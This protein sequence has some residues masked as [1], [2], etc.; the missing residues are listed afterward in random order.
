MATQL[1]TDGYDRQDDVRPPQQST[2]LHPSPEQVWRALG[3]AS[4]AIISHVTPSGDPRS[5]G[6]V[7]GIAG[8][9][10]YFAVAPQSWKAREIRDG[11]PVAVT[12]PVRRGGLLSL[13]VPIPPA[14]VS[15]HARAIVHPANSIDLGAVSKRLE[16]LV[17]KER[18]TAIIIELVPEGS[19]LAYGIGVSLREMANPVAALAHVPIASRPPMG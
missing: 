17:P 19:F 9:H 8:G 13:V 11:Q 10:L 5:S 7:Y 1:A 16:S 2:A 18:R 15:F 4:F 14:T 12:V 3:K 6:V